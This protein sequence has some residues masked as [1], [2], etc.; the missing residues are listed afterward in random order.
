MHQESL[1]QGLNELKAAIAA[2]VEAAG[3]CKAVAQELWPDLDILKAIQ[4]LSNACNSK[5][6]AELDYHEIQIVKR[7]ARTASG[8]S[9]IHA[10]E[11][12]PLDCDLKWVTQQERAERVAVKIT[13]AV[14]LLQQTMTE[15]QE[16]LRGLK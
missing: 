7:L 10:Y 12:K 11:S 13:D 15:A 3:G 1:F 9:H 5:Q 8:A 2:D 14:K 4:K 6:K 16:L